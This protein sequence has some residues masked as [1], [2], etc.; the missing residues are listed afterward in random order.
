MD[1]ERDN[2]GGNTQ[3]APRLSDLVQTVDFRDG[4]PHTLRLIGPARRQAR[5]WITT[6][7]KEGGKNK[8]FPKICLAYNSETGEFDGECPYCDAGI[9]A[10]IEVQQNAIDRDIQEEGPPKKAGEPTKFERKLREYLGYEAYFKESIDTKLWTPARVV[11]LN[12]SPAIKVKDTVAV[13][14]VKMK[15]GTKKTFPPNHPKYGYDLVIQYH[16]DKKR[17]ASDKYSVVKDERNALT[18]EELNYALWMLDLEKPEKLSVAKEEMKRLKS[19]LWR[20]D[21]DEDEDDMPKKKKRHQEEDDDFD[22]KSSRSKKRSRDDDE[23]EDEDERSSRKSSKKRS[24][25]WDDDEEDDDDDDEVTSRKRGKSKSDDDDDEE[26]DDRRRSKRSNSRK[27]R[28]DDE[29]E[30]D[31]EDTRRSSKK[32]RVTDDDEEEEDN[33]KSSKRRS[34]DDD[35]DDDEDEDERSSR[36]KRSR[37]DD[38]DDRP[39]KKS[40]KRRSRDDDDE[41]ED[42][43][44]DRPSKKSSKKRSLRDVDDDDDDWDSDDD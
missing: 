36:K 18:E 13:N 24:Q 6:K 40:S 27:S 3:K 9:R 37:D 19:R 26:E 28:N 20:E 16:D 2:V 39:S 35:D 7:N 29:D 34:R 31:E 12:T 15:D 32:R 5:H 21:G 1:W 8:P 14:K 17:A 30:D 33:R 41:D 22:E 44:E 10:S 43:D 11:V 4:K 38:D 23:D 25:D 42:E